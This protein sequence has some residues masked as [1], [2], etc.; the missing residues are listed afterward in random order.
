MAPLLLPQKNILKTEPKCDWSR[1]SF[2][3]LRILFIAVLVVCWWCVD[4]VLVVCWWCVGGVLMVC[5]WCV[6]GDR[7]T[8]SRPIWR[9][10]SNNY[11]TRTYRLIKQSLMRW[12][13]VGGSQ[14]SDVRM[15]HGHDHEIG[16]KSVS[17]MRYNSVD[18]QL[19]KFKYSEHKPHWIDALCRTFVSQ[20]INYWQER[21]TQIL[22]GSA[23]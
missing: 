3:E 19:R 15:I 8:L 17:R 4:G 9:C 6:D 2:P 11:P 1:D 10:N 22:I 12:Q 16:C 20:A 5:W 21:T 13:S 14:R 18:T 7:K 23:K